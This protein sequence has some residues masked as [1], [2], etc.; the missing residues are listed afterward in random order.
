MI[1]PRCTIG[2]HLL[3]KMPAVHDHEGP[4]PTFRPGSGCAQ[5]DH[6]FSLF[7]PLLQILHQKFKAVVVGVDTAY[8]DAEC[9]ANATVVLPPPAYTAPCSDVS[10]IFRMPSGSHRAGSSVPAAHTLFPVGLSCSP[11]TPF[12]L[13]VLPPRGGSAHLTPPVPLSENIPQ[14]KPSGHKIRSQTIEHRHLLPLRQTLFYFFCKS[15]QACRFF[16]FP[17]LKEL[18][19]K[20]FRLFFQHRKPFFDPPGISNKFARRINA[21]SIQI[22][23]ERWLSTSKL[24]MESISSPHSSDADRI[25]F[26]QRKNVE[27]TASYGKLSAPSTCPTRS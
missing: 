15:F 27:N 22:S 16:C 18:I 1:S 23:M 7:L 5:Q 9:S 20:P 11:G 13:P 25:F 19:C 26:G 3:N 17:F 4:L 24:R 12:R 14:T 8:I 21:D 10:A 6:A 2:R